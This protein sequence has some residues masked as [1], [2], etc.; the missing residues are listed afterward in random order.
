MIID[1][2]EHF[3][4]IT[5]PFLGCLRTGSSLFRWDHVSRAVT[6]RRKVRKMQ[7]FRLGNGFACVM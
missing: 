7:E 2:F 6:Y 5:H 4:I 1:A 3:R